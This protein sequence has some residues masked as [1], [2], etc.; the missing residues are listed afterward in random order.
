MNIQHVGRSLFQG[1]RHCFR[2]SH[3]CIVTLGL[4]VGLIHLPFWLRDVV[5]GTL[6]GAGSLLL[7]I[8]AAIG[9]YMVWQKR[10]QLANLMPSDEDRWIGYCIIFSGIFVAPFC[11]TAEWSQKILLMMIL[12]GVAI[13]SWGLSF[14]SQYPIPVFLIGLGLFPN[15]YA[16]SRDIWETFTPPYLLDNV[17]AAV[18]TFGLSLIGQNAENTGRVIDLSGKAVYVDWACNGFNLSAEVAVGSII[19]GL[20]LKQTLPKIVMLT[21]VG[22]AL[23]LIFNVPRIMLMAMANAYWGDEAFGFWHGLWGGQIFSCIV[24]TIYY[25]IVMAVVNQKPA[26]KAS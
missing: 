1:F 6:V 21:S 25:Y 15:G 18:S 10:E 13:S 16:V 9:I 20:L 26:K 12:L 8:A 19:L 14:F 5:M 3:A 11:A 23:A 4:A 2:S 17:M 7:L 24:F 22:I